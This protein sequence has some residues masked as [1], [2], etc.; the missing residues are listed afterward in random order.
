MRMA[1][2]HWYAIAILLAGAAIGYLL[3]RLKSA[4]VLAELSAARSRADEVGRQ[5][6][7]VDG[8]RRDLLE[9]VRNIS[10]QLASEQQKAAG[11]EES[12]AAMKAATSGAIS[13][14]FGA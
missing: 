9:Q 11:L 6:E 10:T 7:L 1:E 8:E 3:G 12:R 4:G 13:A 2:F 5:R 14:L